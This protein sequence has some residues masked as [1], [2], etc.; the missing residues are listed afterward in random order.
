MCQSKYCRPTCILL[1]AR[2]RSSQSND[3]FSSSSCSPMALMYS[4][5]PITASARV[6]TSVSRISASAA[7]N[8]NL[9]G[10]S[11]RK[12]LMVILVFSSPPL[13]NSNWSKSAA[14]GRLAA[15]GA[16]TGFFHGLKEMRQFVLLRR[17]FWCLLWLLFSVFVHSI[18]IHVFI[19]VIAVLT[20][21]VAL[22]LVH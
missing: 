20:I 19:L 16:T 6:A 2:S 15:F 3:L 10:F 12:R 5:T 17:S 22:F 14:F 18:T 21:N 9:S 7:L 13:L 8:W 4:Q 11:S 1:T